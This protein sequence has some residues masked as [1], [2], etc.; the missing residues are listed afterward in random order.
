MDAKRWQYQCGMLAFRRRNWCW[1]L[2]EKSACLIV[3]I[4][5][6]GKDRRHRHWLVQ[7]RKICRTMKG[8]TT[9]SLVHIIIT[10][11]KHS[12]RVISHKNKERERTKI[13]VTI[14]R[15]E[16]DQSES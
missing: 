5:F 12:S 4:D 2:R 1:G 13:V 9:T 15:Y 3:I 10:Q 8:T 11:K 6:D 16:L 14:S 7:V